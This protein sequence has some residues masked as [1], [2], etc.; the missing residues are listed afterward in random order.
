M[1]TTIIEK[2]LKA[3]LPTVEGKD[4]EECVRALQEI[5]CVKDVDSSAEI[6]DGEAVLLPAMAWD[7]ILNQ[8]TYDVLGKRM[9]THDGDVPMSY[10]VYDVRKEFLGFDSIPA[11]YLSFG[12]EI[13]SDLWKDNEAEGSNNPDGTYNNGNV[14]ASKKVAADFS[15]AEL[16]M[17]CD[18]LEAAL[19]HTGTL[20][21]QLIER[22]TI[23]SDMDYTWIPEVVKVCVDKLLTIDEVCDTENNYVFTVEATDVG[24]KYA[25]PKQSTVNIT[26]DKATYAWRL[27]GQMEPEIMANICGITEDEAEALIDEANEQ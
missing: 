16:H 8:M 15:C 3:Y 21:S 6:W 5:A 7:D 23:D 12:Y 20:F 10:Y 17:I 26:G 11:C 18:V 27:I 4:Q 9:R 13:L 1:N 25:E 2:A 24:T 14:L 22:G 19:S